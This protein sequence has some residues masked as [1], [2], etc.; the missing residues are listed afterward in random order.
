M[1]KFWKRS[2]EEDATVPTEPQ[3]TRKQSVRERTGVSYMREEYCETPTAPESYT[4]PALPRRSPASRTPSASTP[5]QPDNTHLYTSSTYSS[6]SSSCDSSS[7]S[8]DGGS[9]S[10]SSSCD[11]GG[12]F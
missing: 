4:R 2:T 11:G 6:P 12:G 8:Y 3:E 10:F 9:S 1:K 5:V 7:S